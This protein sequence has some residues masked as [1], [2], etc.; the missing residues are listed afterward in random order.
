MNY[1]CDRYNFSLGKNPTAINGLQPLCPNVEA[2][3]GD[4]T[5]QN[6][7][8]S[9]KGYKCCYCWHKY[10]LD[11]AI[12][13]EQRTL[14]NR[15]FKWWGNGKCELNGSTV[16]F[17]NYGGDYFYNFSRIINYGSSMANSSTAQ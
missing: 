2:M 11:E 4:G 8:A 1:E 14:N 16:T 3:L 10:M 9:S 5:A 6:P 13:S 17:T 15:A 7:Y 12:W